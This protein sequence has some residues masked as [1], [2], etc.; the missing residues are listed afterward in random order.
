LSKPAN[1]KRLKRDERKRGENRISGAGAQGTKETLR[2]A[3]ENAE[4]R[5]D[6]QQKGKEEEEEN[7]NGSN[8]LGMEICW[9]GRQKE[10]QIGLGGLT[11]DF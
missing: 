3:A 1:E 7:V 10:E 11:G 2:K 4:Q 9:L 5:V 6:Q 8:R